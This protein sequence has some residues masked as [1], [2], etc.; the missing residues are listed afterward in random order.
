M[1]MKNNPSIEGET[2]LVSQYVEDWGSKNVVRVVVVNPN[3]EAS[4]T[5]AVEELSATN[6]YVQKCTQSQE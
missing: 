6:T 3:F 4:L 1:T 5:K 2:W